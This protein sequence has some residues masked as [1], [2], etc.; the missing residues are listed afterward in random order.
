MIAPSK[1]FPSYK[2]RWLS[3]QPSEGLLKA[4]VFLGVL[5][6]LKQCE[7]EAYSSQSLFDELERVQ[8]DTNT[9]MTLA[10]DTER[11]LIRN[12]GQYWR[13]T[14][15]L[16]HITGEIQLT[17][18]GQEVASGRITND[19]FTALMIRNTILPNPQ[20]YSVIETQR[21]RDADL[22]IKPLE[23]ILAV[24]D[25]LGRQFSVQDSYLSANELIKIIIPLSGDKRGVDEIIQAVYDFRNGNLEVSTWPD[26]APA[27]N[28]KRLAR[29]FLLFLENFGVC[30]TGVITDRYEQKF[31]LDHVL[32][33]TIQPD[34]DRTFLE[35]STIINEEITRSKSSE[36]PLIIERRRVAASV[37]RRTAQPRFRREVLEA[38][39]SRCILTNESIP[40]VLEAAH[41]IPVGSGGSDIVDNGFCMRVDI[42][43]L[44]DGGKIRIKSNGDVLLNANTQCS[45]SY[46]NL[47]RRV[48]F[49]ES[50]NAA[51][52]EWRMRYY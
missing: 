44:Y 49:P 31:H 15:L 35:D 4:P 37:I 5:R 28:D 8:T 9:D 1:P 21:W 19:E 36:I 25:G 11:N 23:L 47:P 40:S 32:A 6:A 48:A 41:I 13:G 39:N 17:D 52:V 12:S 43:R 46:D 10:R 51:N 22:R 20:I 34:S 42:H 18:L 7:G 29:E 2:W 45:V 38:S 33:H 50:V 16:S 24:M 3:V 30:R 27:A 14:G 26:C